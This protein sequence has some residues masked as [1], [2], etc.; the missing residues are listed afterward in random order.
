MDTLQLDIM[1]K[2]LTENIV[3]VKKRINFAYFSVASFSTKLDHRINF[4]SKMKNS[5]SSPNTPSL[6]N[7][8]SSLRKGHIAAFDL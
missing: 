7:K 5:I 8:Y 1:F 6:P 3:L 2:D 4:D